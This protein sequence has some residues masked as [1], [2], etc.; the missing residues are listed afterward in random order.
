MPMIL[1]ATANALACRQMALPLLDLANTAADDATADI[2]V[3]AEERRQEGESVEVLE[4]A[5]LL[6]EARLNNGQQLDPAIEKRYE[7]RKI[8]VRSGFVSSLSYE[9]SNSQ[10]IQSSITD[11]K[12]GREAGREPSES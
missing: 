3:A 4:E 10:L 12:A 1:T 11:C 8:D 6:E 9:L 5:I 2:Q 7:A